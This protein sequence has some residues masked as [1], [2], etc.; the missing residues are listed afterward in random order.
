MRILSLARDYPKAHSFVSAHQVIHACL[1]PPTSTELNH[2]TIELPSGRFS[3]QKVLDQL[4]ADWQPDCIQISSSLG[5][6]ARE[7]VTPIGLDK[8]NCPTVMK[9]TDSHFRHRP[10]QSLIEYA[11]TVKCQYH[12]TTYDRHHLHFFREAGLKNVFWMPGSFSIQAYQPKVAS[13]KI[14][15]VLFC[16]ANSP[17][18]HPRRAKLLG[19]LQDAGV[20]VTV[21][22]KSY[23][24]SLEAYTAAHIVFNCSLN[25]DLNRRVFETLMAGG[26]LVT[27]RLA[28]ESGLFQ[29]FREG[30]HLECY[31]SEQELLEKVEYY[32]AHRDQ[33]A[34]IARQGQEHF[35]QNYHPHRLEEQFLDVVVNGHPIPETFLVKDDDR[36]HRSIQ[37]YAFKPLRDRIRL[38]ELIHDLHRC[39]DHLTLL[40]WQAQHP[41]IL[42]DL[43]DLSRLQILEPQAQTVQ[44]ALLDCP[45]DKQQLRTT[46]VQLQPLLQPGGI[47]LILGQSAKRFDAAI[48]D[49]GWQP[50]QLQESG[51]GACRVYQNPRMMADET[52][53]PLT[54]PIKPPLS[55]STQLV[56]T[57]K[58]TAKKIL[59]TLQ[60]ISA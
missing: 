10:I 34:R 44:I 18:L 1:N 3:I 21:T 2:P 29:L 30:E 54:L 20:N 16:G 13:E 23:T 39:N 40:D 4:P 53:E 31:G 37:N 42:T 46:L 51:E 36:T 14:Y 58:T 41:E 26:F 33:A 47:V 52:I 9:L 27:D 5:V 59:S 43:R 38:Y 11:Q 35:L 48:R 22:R 32:L 25:G 60:S 24:E 50:I 56:L 7:P 49:W 19:F 8:V 15:D 45:A 57:T 28:P 17:E 55:L 6:F 12:W